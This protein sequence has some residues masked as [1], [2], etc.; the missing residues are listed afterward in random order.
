L[1]AHKLN[2]ARV[3]TCTLDVGIER[4]RNDANVGP[5]GDKRVKLGG[6][7]TSAPDEHHGSSVQ[8]QEDGQQ[9][10]HSPK[11]KKP[12]K[13]W[14]SRAIGLFK[15]LIRNVVSTVATRQTVALAHV[16][17]QQQQSGEPPDTTA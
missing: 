17:M 3:G 12:G 4:R 15:P 11:S 6:G 8:V 5:C 16:A 10:L 7:D 9:A 2:G 13:H 14:A 1:T